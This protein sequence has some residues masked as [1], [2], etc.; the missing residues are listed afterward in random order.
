VLTSNS[1]VDG[2]GYG[3]NIAAGA[4][5]NDIAFVIT[6]QFYNGEVNNFVDYGQPVPADFNA[7]FPTY[8][9]FTQVVWVGST[10]VGCASVDCSASGLQDT[11]T[12]VAPIFHVC[13]YYPAGM[14][15]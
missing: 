11:G 1:N 4:G 12:G 9:H 15:D 10:S 13:N 14:I 6:E 2:G 5:I 8:G 7:A 3:Q